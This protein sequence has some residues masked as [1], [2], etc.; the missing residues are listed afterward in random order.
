MNPRFLEP[1]FPRYWRYDLLFGLI[2]MEAGGAQPLQDAEVLLGLGRLV[3]FRDSR[4]QRLP[5]SDDIRQCAQRL[6][7][8]E[9]RN[10]AQRAG[11]DECMGMGR[12]LSFIMKL[13]FPM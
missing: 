4:V 8:G 10:R 12:L 9:Y 3:V 5:L 11:H 1:A 13:F 6:L 2:V 7:H